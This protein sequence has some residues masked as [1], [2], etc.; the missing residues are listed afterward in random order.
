M[1]ANE[2]LVAAMNAANE[3]ALKQKAINTELLKIKVRR[4]PLTTATP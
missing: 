1:Q 3:D 2:A 4:Q